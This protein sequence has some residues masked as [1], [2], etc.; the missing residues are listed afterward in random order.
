MGRVRAQMWRLAGLVTMSAVLASASFAMSAK[1]STLFKAAKPDKNAPA[2]CQS[3]DLE[4]YSPPQDLEIASET[5]KSHFSVE[6]ASNEAEREQGLMCRTALKPGQGMLFEFPD[7]DE[8]NFWMKNTLIGLDIIYIGSD[9]HIVSIQ[10][11]AKPFDQT[12]L[13]SNGQATGVLEIAAGLS[14]KLGLKAGDVVQH[15][16]FHNR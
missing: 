5:R 15:P 12:P 8:R 11:N 14:D 9:G 16:F 10:K 4:P 3:M 1:P 13:P 6:I 2:E 7:N